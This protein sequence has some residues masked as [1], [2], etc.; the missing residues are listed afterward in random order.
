M[1]TFTQRWRQLDH[2]DIRLRINSK[3]PRDVE[4]A[5]A[6]RRP[7]REDMLALLSPAAAGYL[8]PMAQKAHAL[9]RQRFGN[10]VSFYVPL[11]LSNLCA[12]DCTYCG[13]SMS[14]HLKR[15]TLDEDEIARE[16][17]AIRALGFSHLLLV[18]GEH[19]TK[20]GMDY[21]RRHLPYIRSQFSSLQM[22]VQP[23][24]E[25]EYAELKNL[26]LDGVMVYQETYHEATYARHHLRGKKQDFFWRLE[27]PDRLGRA[28][29]DRI[30]L[31]ALIG[32]SDSWRVDCYMVA[33]HL[34]WLQQHY[35]QSR[36]SV[37]FPRLR[38]CAGGVQPASLMDERQLLQVI[39]AFRI[40]SPDVELSLSTRESPWFRDHVVPLVINHVSAFS[41]T[42]PGGYA[43]GDKPELEQF[44]PHD[45]RTPDEVAQMLVAA[46]LQ[47]VWKDWDGYLGRPAR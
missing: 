24:A 14:N 35:W 36:Y 7:D 23:L 26:G 5:L 41:R 33:E 12:N 21:F 1:E 3:T 13:F 11:Y 6:A 28:G 16:C 18:T 43:D 20:V 38:P 32:L 31:G 2:D 46:G 40:M 8:E 34:L 9:T 44:A 30:G 27:T 47:P 22:E 4:A 37:S 29:I 39:C 10:T 15:K 19:Q 17:A 42:Q 25:E 45:G